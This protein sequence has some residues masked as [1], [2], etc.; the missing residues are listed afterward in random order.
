MRY[1]FI[2]AINISD[3]KKQRAYRNQYLTFHQKNIRSKESNTRVDYRLGYII[4]IHGLDC[5]GV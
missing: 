1:E 4:R 5:Y 2:K 3:F